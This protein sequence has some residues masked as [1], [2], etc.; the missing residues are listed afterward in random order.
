MS[1][2]LVLI[3]SLLATRYFGQGFPD[4]L[5]SRAIVFMR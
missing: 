4:F 2:A 1:E 3:Y 5:S